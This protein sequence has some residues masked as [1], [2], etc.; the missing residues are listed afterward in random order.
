MIY[1]G[2]NSLKNQKRDQCILE[3]QSPWTLYCYWELSDLKKNMVQHHLNNE[4]SSLKLKLRLYDIT[5]LSFNGHNAHGYQD[6][7]TQEGSNQTVFL[8]VLSNKTYC[9]DVGFVTSEDYFFVLLRSN[10]VDTPVALQ[11]ETSLITK[12]VSNWKKDKDDLPSWIDN[13]SS[14]SYYEK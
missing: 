2:E 5:A 14:Y 1:R 3:V 12:A 9:V 11:T 4:W 7:Y 8:H 13:F 6:F 10:Q